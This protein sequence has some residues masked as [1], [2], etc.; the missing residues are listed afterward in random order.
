MNYYMECCTT[1]II[2]NWRRDS[3]IILISPLLSGWL[4]ARPGHVRPG[5]VQL[6]L[7]V[8][9]ERARGDKKLVLDFEERKQPIKIW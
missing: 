6:N 5:A 7:T 4:P 3:F 2:I 8:N 1:I 9:A